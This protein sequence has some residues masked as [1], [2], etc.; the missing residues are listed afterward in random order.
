MAESRTDDVNEMNV[1]CS[2]QNCS[3]GSVTLGDD[4]DDDNVNNEK[5]RDQNNM[6]EPIEVTNN[7]ESLFLASMHQNS[8]MIKTLTD[9]LA[10]LQR[11]LLTNKTST[12]DNTKKVVNSSPELEEPCTSRSC[13]SRSENGHNCAKKRKLDDNDTNDCHE[14]DEFDNILM[15]S[16]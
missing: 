12:L 1:D 6:A 3:R 11:Q 16:D 5:S 15:D 8:Q 10:N 2:I 9:N 13:T 14:R 7:V 4:D